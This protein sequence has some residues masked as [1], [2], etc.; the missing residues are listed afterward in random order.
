M[1]TAGMP[2]AAGNGPALSGQKRIWECRP[3]RFSHH[4]GSRR[5]AK[6]RGQ[7][8]RCRRLSRLPILKPFFQTLSGIL[9]H[10]CVHRIL[11]YRRWPCRG[12]LPEGVPVD[13]IAVEGIGVIT[14]ADEVARR[15]AR[16][17][18]TKE[19]VGTII[20][21]TIS[22]PGSAPRAAAWESC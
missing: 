22:S 7:D 2:L 20:T 18:S 3:R 13:S 12:P 1:C 15:A 19:R 11:V 16:S 8:G 10:G 5:A 14:V 21:A 6:V 9:W 17:V 4:D